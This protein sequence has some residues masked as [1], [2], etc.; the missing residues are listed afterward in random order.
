MNDKIAVYDLET[1]E[2]H[3]PESFWVL[4]YGDFGEDDP[5]TFR[6]LLFEPSN[7]INKTMLIKSIQKSGKDAKRVF[8]IPGNKFAEIFKNWKV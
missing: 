7:Q 4:V 8:A 1:I 2:E 3:Y 5:R 6:H